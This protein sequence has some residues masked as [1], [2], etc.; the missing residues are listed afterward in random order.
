M[1]KDT[2]DPTRLYLA[3][4][5]RANCRVRVSSFDPLFRHSE[6]STLPS[7][8][9]CPNLAAQPTPSEVVLRRCRTSA[10]LGFKN[11]QASPSAVTPWA[12]HRHGHDIACRYASH[13]SCACC[14]HSK[15]SSCVMPTPQ[16]FLRRH[17]WSQHHDRSH[18]KMRVQMGSIYVYLLF[19]LFS[20]WTQSVL[21]GNP[22]IIVSCIAYIR[23]ARLVSASQGC[24]CATSTKRAEQQ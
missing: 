14:A 12:T 4:H 20:G 3:S 6:L 5:T 19:G 2:C 7:L 9:V 17:T 16:S 8:C 24:G 18:F 23:H 13:S 10:C 11:S 22:K 21:H 1:S 15:R